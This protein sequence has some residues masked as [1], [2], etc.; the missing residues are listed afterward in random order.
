[1]APV[2]TEVRT[3]TNTNGNHHKQWSI[4][5]VEDQNRHRFYTSWGK[6][7]YTPFSQ[8][9]GK[10]KWWNYAANRNSAAEKLIKTKLSEGYIHKLTTNNSQNQSPPVESPLEFVETDIANRIRNIIFD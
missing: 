2:T 5:F 9:P 1:M 3:F 10:W 8:L 7:G 6:I 4:H